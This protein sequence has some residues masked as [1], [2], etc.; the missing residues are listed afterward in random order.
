MWTD[1]RRPRKA[2]PAWWFESLW[3]GVSS[4]F[5]SASHVAHLVL[6]PHSVRLSVLPNVRQHLPAEL[7][8]ATEAKGKLHELLRG[9][10]P[11]PC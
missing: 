5:P 10:A 1:T 6:S 11:S 7:D 3:P 4:R 8:S 2:A 9:G